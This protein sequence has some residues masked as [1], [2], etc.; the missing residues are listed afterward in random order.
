VFYF[1]MKKI[2]FFCLF[3]PRL[4]NAQ[5]PNNAK[6][7]WV[8]P[9][10]YD[11]YA[12]SVGIDAVTFDFS[13]VA[14]GDTMK[15]SYGKQDFE[16]FN[17]NASL[18]NKEGQL[19][20]YSNYCFF[21]NK[22]KVRVLSQYSF[23]VTNLSDILCNQIGGG[24]GSNMMILLPDNYHENLFHAFSEP[25]TQYNFG[26]RGNLFFYSRLS[27]SDTG[28][29]A[30]LIDS[31]LKNIENDSFFNIGHLSA[32]LHGNGKDWWVITSLINKNS[33]Q[34]LLVTDGKVIGPT[35]QTIG[36]PFDLYD[37]NT[38]NSV[39]SPD[40]TKF[41]DYAIHSDIQIFD[42]DR[43]T[44]MLSN[45]IHI[46]IQDSSD[47]YYAV[48]VAFSNN[49]RF[50]YAASSFKVY[51]FDMQAPDIA[52]SKIVVAEYDGF[53]DT[54]PIFQILF[55]QLRLA[56]DN[57]IYC[58]SPGG[59]RYIHVIESPD[60]PGLACNFRQHAKRLPTAITGGLPNFP[61][62]RLG[63]TNP[64]CAVPVVDITGEHGFLNIYP[65]PASELLWYETNAPIGTPWIITNMM[66]KTILSGET[67]SGKW[68]K[69]DLLDLLSGCYTMTIIDKKPKSRLI[70]KQ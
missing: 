58:T 46:P 67:N 40:G 18:C 24:T 41:A 31:T 44:G 26:I 13:G 15:I 43:C 21:G 22:D 6:R 20:L 36:V 34:K 56:P 59:R 2:L 8:W 64:P 69:I 54:D 66:G 30:E 61:Y 11:Y 14:N 50:L 38:G 33:F 7:D 55:Y 10:G 4:T 39:F 42:F 51:Q 12:D 68:T 1:R 52:A 32:C 47:I 70:V 48:G 25:P 53:Y 37:G 45:P 35:T 62:Y 19:E 28:F 17:T 57:K 29:V 60:L 3:L 16:I 23:N 49:S 27:N 63:A 5:V 65:N 9:L